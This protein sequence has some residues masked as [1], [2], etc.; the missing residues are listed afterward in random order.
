[1]FD[2]FLTISINSSSVISLMALSSFITVW[3]YILPFS[4]RTWGGCGSKIVPTLMIA[5]FHWQLMPLISTFISAQ[6]RNA[7]TQQPHS[8]T[9]NWTWILF[10]MQ[11]RD[12]VL[13]Y[14][15]LAST[16]LS[17]NASD[18]ND[19]LEYQSFTALKQEGS[20]SLQ[21]FY[22]SPPPYGLPA[23]QYL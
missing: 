21:L 16:L 10:A 8:N 7:A 13:D 18:V 6:Y 12:V 17:G 20:H 23:E 14:F 11:V 4:Y 1:M 5:P 9:M 15:H 22:S 19:L 3:V 2:A